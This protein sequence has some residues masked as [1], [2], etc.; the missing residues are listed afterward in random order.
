M[1]KI[2]IFNID[3]KS[4]SIR[5]I[6]SGRRDS[7]SQQGQRHLALS[8]IIYVCVCYVYAQKRLYVHTVFASRLAPSETEG[9]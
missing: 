3:I 1:T 9:K 6:I 4:T 5:L 8:V 7:W 2:S